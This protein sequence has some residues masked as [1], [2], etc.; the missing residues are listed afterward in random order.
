[1]K[2]LLLFLCAIALAISS[3]AQLLEITELPDNSSKQIP[4]GKFSIVDINSTL[5][6]K[7]NKPD[8]A[9]KISTAT[10]T[11]N[12]LVE[13]INQLNFILQNQIEILKIL[14]DTCKSASMNKN[15]KVLGNYSKLMTEFYSRIMQNDTLRKEA[16]SLI[17]EYF[18][19]YNKIDKKVYPTSETYLLKKL[20]AQSDA[21]QNQIENSESVNKV[22]VQLVAYLLTQNNNQSKVHI[23]NF[24]TY[25]AGEFYKVERFVTTFSSEEL[26]A[27]Q[28]TS[29]LASQL[30][31]V[32]SNGFKGLNDL[33]SADVPS[34]RSAMNL[35]EQLK[36][37][38][39]GKDS[40]IYKNEEQA[41]EFMLKLQ[42]ELTSFTEIFGQLMQSGDSLLYK[43]NDAE[44]EFD[45]WTKNLPA[46]IDSLTNRFIE[47]LI[48][49]N[50]PVIEFKDS[51]EQFNKYLK[52]DLTNIKG[53]ADYVA[54]IFKPFKGSANTANEISGDVLKFSINQIPDFGIIN[55]QTTGQRANRDELILKLIL[56]KQ[57]E[58]SSE[59]IR[60]T[61]EYKTLNLQQVSLYSESK[62]SLILASPYNNSA[63][64][65]LASRFQFAP[66]GSLLFK[67]GSRNSPAWNYLNPGLGINMS[68]PDFNMDG[69]PDVAFGA[70][71]SI[72]KDLAM[73]G[74]SY[75]IQ[76]G[77]PFWFF[78]LSL[79][80]SMPGAPVNTIQTKPITT[81]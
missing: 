22:N 20:S 79:P 38:Q 47:Q 77:S 63:K 28:T 48:E 73:I 49:A 62:V 26:Q 16:N 32:V 70:V 40:L 46:E 4:L 29:T 21:L 64:V 60:E 44:A 53:M 67:F 7:I 65:T 27:F 13:Q 19:N 9:L 76:T 51:L 81:N 31:N 30:N 56:E 71:F 35:L 17:A 78:G 45:Q 37:F 54:H 24:D 10:N 15:L 72:I 3:Y 66:S 69:T 68:T 8:L 61:I 55:L 34:Y 39:D 2:Q 6:V 57:D 14:Q 74:W 58:N 52:T 1:M 41:R 36:D 75:N 18:E 59:T 12:A 43:Y 23:E 80:F 11:N 42:T 5:Q 50:H 33:L 25:Q